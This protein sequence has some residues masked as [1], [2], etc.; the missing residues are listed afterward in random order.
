MKRIVR[1]T[2]S[3]LTRIVRRVIKEEECLETPKWLV[4]FTIGQSKMNVVCNYLTWYSKDYDEGSGFKV[5]V[6]LEKTE[7]A[8]TVCSMDD[9]LGGLKSIS[10][11]KQETNPS[12]ECPEFIYTFSNS[13]ENGDLNRMLD[14]IKD[15]LSSD[16]NKLKE[17]DLTRIVRRVINE[18]TESQT[19]MD[20]SSDLPRWLKR[21]R[22]GE[23]YIE[24]E[25][26]PTDSPETWRRKLFLK[27]GTESNLRYD[28]IKYGYNTSN[29]KSVFVRNFNPENTVEV[30]CDKKTVTS[31]ERVNTASIYYK[32][33]D[34]SKQDKSDIEWLVDY[35]ERIPK[36]SLVK[37]KDNRKLSMNQYI[38]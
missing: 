28:I 29:Q 2:E 19:D 38:K 23:D 3:D 9:T 14:N 1:L 8:V 22:Y 6:D 36:R 4:N 10:G 5:L 27:D 17:S 21:K 24:V 26:K 25:Y 32:E 20:D 37:T 33:L 11:G 31:S 13:K 18:T 15:I 34:K 30:L 16:V 35:C 7:L 12:N